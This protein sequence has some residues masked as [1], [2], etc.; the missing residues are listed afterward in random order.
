MTGP[1]Q[2]DQLS[3][4][5]HY[6][7]SSWRRQRRIRERDQLDGFGAC[8]FHLPGRFT[9]RGRR[10]R[11]R[12]HRRRQRRRQHLRDGKY[13]L[14]KFPDFPP[15]V[16]LRRRHH[17]AFVAKYA[18]ATP[19]PSSFRQRA[20]PGL[21]EPRISAS[22]IVSPPHRLRWP[23]EPF[24]LSTV[25]L[26]AVH[27]YSSP[28]NLS[29]SV[30]GT[31]SPL[32]ACSTTSFSPGKVTPTA[33]GA[34]STLTITTTAANAAMFVPRKV[35]Y[36]MWLPIAGMSLVGIGFGSAHSR[37]RKLLG[38]LMIGMVV[39]ALLL[40]PACGGSSSGGGGGGRRRRWHTRRLL[41]CYHHGDWH[42]CNTTTAIYTSNPDGQL[43]ASPRLK[44]P[45]PPLTRGGPVFS[46]R[47]GGLA[48]WTRL[49]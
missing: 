32:P 24:G 43:S 20:F 17:D 1:D 31:G 21:S 7:G 27:G 35:F 9:G 4:S 38:F 14:Y 40:M 19:R 2:L 28:V 44:K 16:A 13:R 30:S 3:D 6:P 18:Q 49:V 47:A 45:R 34:T 41:H 12:S 39:A 22:S 5:G 48:R 15:P 29:C 42:R 23:L 10:R 33:V 26:T 37:R 11:L 46:D 8:L 25:T 36:A